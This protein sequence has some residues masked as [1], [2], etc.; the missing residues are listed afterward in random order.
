MIQLEQVSLQYDNGTLALDRIRCGIETGEWVTIT[1]PN[2]AGKTALF[3]VLAMIERPTSGRVMVN[4]K[5]IS[6]LPNSRIPY[7][8]R[9]LGLLFQDQQLLLRKT[10][11][12]NLMFPL[13]ICGYTDAEAR[14]RA[15]AAL[16]RV[17][18]TRLADQWVGELSIG[19]RQSLCI[20]RAIINKPALVLADEPFYNL[21]IAA[22]KRVLHMFKMI[23]QVGVTVIITTQFTSMVKNYPTRIIRLNEG[24]IVPEPTAAQPAQ[25][26]DTAVSAASVSTAGENALVTGQGIGSGIYAD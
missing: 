24:I 1:G 15:F 3:N 6:A 14:E 10:A 18:L 22:I 11:V 7:Y 25:P 17:G 8:R 20:A 2:G 9:S 13:Q 19:E 4:G 23:S 21:D 26:A 16:E 12:E 5:E